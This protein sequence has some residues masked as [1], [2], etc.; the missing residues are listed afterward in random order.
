MESDTSMV[1][2]LRGQQEYFTPSTKILT[3]TSLWVMEV[4]ALTFLI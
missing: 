1:I 3:Y 2:Y 4:M